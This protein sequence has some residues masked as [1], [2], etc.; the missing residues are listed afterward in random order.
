MGNKL[1]S[2]WLREDEARALLAELP[3]QYEIEPFEFTSSRQLLKVTCK[4]HGLS[5][6]QGLKSAI[7]EKSKCPRCRGGFADTEDFIRELELLFPNGYDFSQVN[8]KGKTKPV[9]LICDRHGPVEKTPQALLKGRACRSCSS[10]ISLESFKERADAI[11]GE[12]RFDYSRV[13]YRI[14]TD[15]VLLG[16]ELHGDFQQRVSEFL[17]GHGCQACGLDY[18]TKFDGFLSRAKFNHGDSY[19]YDPALWDQSTGR[20]GIQCK[21]HGIFEQYWFNHTAGSGCPECANAAQ[22]MSDEEVQAKISRIHGDKY[23]LKPGSYKSINGPAIIICKEHGEQTGYCGNLMGGSQTRCCYVVAARSNAEIELFEWVGGH[24]SDTEPSRRDLLGYNLE[25]D[26]YIP[27]LNLGIEFNGEYW[28]SDTVVR[29]NSG[30]SAS[31]KHYLKRK[32]ATEAGIELVFVWENDWKNHRQTVETALMELMDALSSGNSY[33]L[34]P[35]L[36]K[37]KNS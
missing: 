3:D 22:R 27:S 32:A 11:Y 14:G 33:S 1:G 16:C 15:S 6:E 24:R 23:T 25:I 7:G 37:L 30:I 2:K 31:S 28:H 19:S 36:T 34:D 10:G 26:I 35:V 18:A 12:D 5:Y 29:A 17:R 21:E 9:V 20:V 8:Y 4:L 13:Q